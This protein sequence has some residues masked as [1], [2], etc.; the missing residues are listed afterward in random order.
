[1]GVEVNC[2]GADEMSDKGDGDAASGAEIV[3]PPH[4]VVGV[5]GAELSWLAVTWVRLQVEPT[6]RG[7]LEVRFRGR[8]DRWRTRVASS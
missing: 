6:C 7:M 5:T 3:T 8:G 4:R 1:M 2:R